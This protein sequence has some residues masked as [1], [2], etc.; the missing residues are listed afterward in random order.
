LYDLIQRIASYY[1]TGPVKDR[2]VAAAKNFRMPYWDWAAVPPTGQSVYPLS[3]GGSPAVSVD[4]PVG[5]QII[6]NPLYSYVFKPLNVA[7][8]P[9]FPASSHSSPL[10]ECY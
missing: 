6:A 8:L 7:D 4:G 5:R 3:V 1:P 10:A 2:Y 9:D